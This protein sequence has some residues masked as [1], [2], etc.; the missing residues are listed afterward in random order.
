[1]CNLC[2]SLIII[3]SVASLLPVCAQ[4]REAAVVIL[5]HGAI[6]NHLINQVFCCYGISI[7]CLHLM[8]LLLK[9]IKLCNL[10]F[11]LLLLELPSNFLVGNLLL[12]FP[13][14]TA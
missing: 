11:N 10:C 13:S 6:V 12:G 1:M 7:C 14:F 9:N 5:V 2:Q 8:N 3:W 4:D